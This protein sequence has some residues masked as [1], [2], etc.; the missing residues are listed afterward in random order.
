[1]EFEMSM[2]SYITR[3]MWSA[4]ILA[5]PPLVAATVVGLVIALVQTLIQLQEQTLPVAI[6]I[7]TVSAILLIGGEALFDPLYILTEEIF[8]NFPVIAR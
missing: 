4:V 5:G 7:I 8:T 3:G 2:V 6:K 1:M